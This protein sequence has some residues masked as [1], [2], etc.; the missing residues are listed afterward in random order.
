MVWRFLVF[1]LKSGKRSLM[2]APYVK[3]FLTVFIVLLGFLG[4]GKRLAAHMS[5][6]DE[7]KGPDYR[8]YNFGVVVNNSDYKLYRSRSLGR[9]GIKNV[10]KFLKKNSL[11]LTSWLLDHLCCTLLHNIRQLYCFL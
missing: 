4:F 7:V 1:T 5:H 9:R 8:R 6:H 2:P 11:P 3:D 10:N